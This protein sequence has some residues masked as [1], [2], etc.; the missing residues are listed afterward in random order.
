MTTNHPNVGIHPT[1][2]WCAT[3]KFP[4][5]G[6]AR[7]MTIWSFADRWWRCILFWAVWCQSHMSSILH[8]DFMYLQT[9]LCWMSFMISDFYYENES[10]KNKFV[11]EWPNFPIK[12]Q[13]RI[14]YMNFQYNLY[15]KQQFPQ[16]NSPSLR[17]LMTARQVCLYVKSMLI[18]FSTMI[19]SFTMNCHIG[20]NY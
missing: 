7:G 20:L 11:S 4:D 19:G 16:Q 10:E 15:T 12:D 2:V 14:W 3:Q 18:S 5:S 8:R 13:R 9:R 6:V 1:Q 17:F